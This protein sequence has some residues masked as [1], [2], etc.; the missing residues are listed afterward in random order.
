MATKGWW[1][2]PGFEPG[3][4][5]TLSEN[6]TPRPTSQ[7]YECWWKSC[8]NATTRMTLDILGEGGAE[9]Q[10]DSPC[11]LPG[12]NRRPCPCEGH[13]ITTTL[14]KP[15][16][17]CIIFV[18]LSQATA[19]KTPDWWECM[20]SRSHGATDNASD[21]GS[22]DCRFESCWDRPNLFFLISPQ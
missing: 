21:Y 8:P 15:L 4:S 9:R 1:A 22:E 5:R 17:T 19:L 16:R 7:R 2:R 18:Q 20:K 14:R 10:K 13:V 3:T 12:S 11:F 6:H